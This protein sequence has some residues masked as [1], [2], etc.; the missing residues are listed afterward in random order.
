MPTFMY[1]SESNGVKSFKLPYPWVDAYTVNTNRV[2]NYVN[3]TARPV[4]TFD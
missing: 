1:F 2:L 3:N 4:F